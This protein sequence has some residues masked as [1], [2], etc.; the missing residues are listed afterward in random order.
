MSNKSAG[1]LYFN[2][3][4]QEKVKVRTV[5]LHKVIIAFFFALLIVA[6][7][8]I[9]AISNKNSPVI[10]KADA[11]SLGI[12]CGDE[13]SIGS[14]VMQST[15]DRTFN[16]A[17]LPDASHRTWSGKELF[18]YTNSIVNYHGESTAEEKPFNLLDSLV[19]EIDPDRAPNVGNINSVRDKLEE[20][21]SATTCF[22]GSLTA[23]GQS[24]LFLVS[25]ELNG[26]FGSIVAMGFDAKL[27]CTNS[28][29]SND[30]GCINLTKIIG[31]TPSNDAVDGGTGR[32]GI[33]GALTNSL[34]FPLITI[35]IALTAL[36]VLYTGIV[37]R[38][39]REALFGALWVVLAFVGGI[40][41]LLN[42][43][44]LSRAPM[45][46]TNSV[47]ACI[48]GAFNGQNCLT[49][50][51]FGTPEIGE[52]TTS[53]FCSSATGDNNVAVDEKMSLTIASL[54][55]SIWRAFV[56]E[57][58][59][60]TT[61]GTSLEELDVNTG[62]ISDVI[63]DAG[64]TDV[65]NDIFCVDMYSRDSR[66]TQMGNEYLVT[67]SGGKTVC[68]LAVYQMSL[69]SKVISEND[70]IPV[71]GEL[72][73]RWYPLIVTVA[74]ND[75]MWNNW[76][77]GFTSGSAN[78]QYAFVS[79]ASTVIG[80]GLLALTGVM[81]LVYLFASIILMAFAPFFF[82]IGVHPGRGKKLFL[83]WAE[84]VISF[85]L[86]YIASVVFLII[87]LSIYA[88]VFTGV[89]SPAMTFIVLIILSVAL[90]LYRKEIVNLLGKANMGGEQI[91]N[92]FG[93]L[94]ADRLKRAAQATAG[95]AVGAFAASDSEGFKGKMGDALSGAGD[96]LRRDLKRGSGVG[97]NALRQL[98]RSSVTNKADF[99]KKAQK[100][101]KVADESE[102]T[103]KEN[104]AE[105]KEADKKLTE[106]KS[107]T[108]LRDAEVTD[109]RNKVDLELKV[110]KEVAL[111]KDENGK[112][113]F[114]SEEQEYFSLDEKLKIADMNIK[115]A[116]ENG[117]EDL[118]KQL[119]TGRAR[120]I[121][122]MQTFESGIDEMALRELKTR[123][124]NSVHERAGEIG[125]K[126]EDDENAV[127]DKYAEAAINKN[128]HTRE[129]ER[130]ENI[131]NERESLRPALEAKF[132]Q[133]KKLADELKDS[134]DDVKSTQILT[135]REKQRLTKAA[136]DKARENEIPVTPNFTP[137]NTS[138]NVN[139]Q[140]INEPDAS[141]SNPGPTV[142]PPR[143]SVLP[144][145]PIQPTSQEQSPKS[146]LPVTPVSKPSLPSI[147]TPVS[148]PSVE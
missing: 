96:G 25:T 116:S 97:A 56:V 31:G 63:D 9:T 11:F 105:I 21:R 24:H 68:N 121:G 75:A 53:D 133:D 128:T 137:K 108:P 102:K 67:N 129:I 45:A 123:F 70:S 3:P 49:E 141:K 35:M 114:S 64:L 14:G 65:K 7:S 22:W 26:L 120:T 5:P 147:Q 36:W 136:E 144:V 48:V 117:D 134:S 79:I 33:I 127:F 85:I 118:V 58:W 143:Q 92:R 81:A 140:I 39:L 125:F 55:C 12:L 23:A 90:F 135:G 27:I 106:L 52:N 74:H 122:A 110:R 46:I 78:Y 113:R 87:A 8:T 84:Q 124:N 139:E 29:T 145:Q 60:Q 131:K 93:D 30:T 138:I 132:N 10:T 77:S 82:L 104:E 109:S 43:S 6:L 100:A 37:K 54:D 126:R 95:S 44:M 59:A 15:W 88:A 86:K 69:Q 40:M 101:S 146:S 72:D 13:N 47:G 89:S 111:S 99:A 28:E 142:T 71:K 57:P 107:R 2:D 19:R 17:V 119:E 148:A 16:R 80:G 34:Y 4:F 130:T 41:L 51:T 20:R 103:Y 66:T 18:Y 112:S 73:E 91:A 83:G 76:N 42:P 1:A 32:D 98:E 115:I 94:S 50:T 61:F 62:K 38:K